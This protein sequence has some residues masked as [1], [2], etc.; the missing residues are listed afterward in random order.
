[1]VRSAIET[2]QYC[3]HGQSVW[4]QAAG[5]QTHE[6]LGSPGSRAGR[7]KEIEK[8]TDGRTLCTTCETLVRSS[9]PARTRSDRVSVFPFPALW[10]KNLLKVIAH[11][12]EPLSVSVCLCTALP[13]CAGA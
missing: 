5:V 9:E 3:V 11:R 10:M 12:P 8:A 1:M 4:L 6:G 13:L 2:R 7:K